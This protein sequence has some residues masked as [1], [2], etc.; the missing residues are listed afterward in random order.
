ML[1]LDAA[2]KEVR[3]V[4]PVLLSRV[5]ARTAAEYEVRAVEQLLLL[6][7]QALWGELEGAKLVHHVK[8]HEVGLKKFYE[9]DDD[10]GVQP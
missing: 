7:A 3:V 4:V 2:G 10:R 5:Q 8:H 6:I 9:T 1:L